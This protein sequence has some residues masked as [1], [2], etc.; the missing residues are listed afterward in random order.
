M[1]AYFSLPPGGRWHAKRDGRSLRCK[2]QSKINFIITPAPSPDFVGSSLPEG[3]YL[4]HRL[5]YS[6]EVYLNRSLWEQ[7]AAPLR[8]RVDLIF[9]CRGRRL[10]VPFIMI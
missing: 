1:N 3:A 8:I 6:G 2:R 5:Y 10:D 9:S 4:K 7:Q